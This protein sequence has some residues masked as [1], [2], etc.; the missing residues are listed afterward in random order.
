MSDTDDRTRALCTHWPASSPPVCVT[1][2]LEQ[3]S[4]DCFV[5]AHNVLSKI[6]EILFLLSYIIFQWQDPLNGG[7]TG[8]DKAQRDATYSFAIPAMIFGGGLFV[9]VLWS[10]RSKSQGVLWRKSFTTSVA[11]QSFV[12]FMLEKPDLIRSGRQEDRVAADMKVAITEK[13]WSDFDLWMHNNTTKW[14][15]DFVFLCLINT[16]RAT[17][18]IA[19]DPAN[20]FLVPSQLIVLVGVLTSLSS[21]LIGLQKSATSVR[22][23]RLVPSPRTRSPHTARTR[24]R[25]HVYYGSWS[26]CRCTRAGLRWWRW[27]DCSISTIVCTISSAVR[28]AVLRPTPRR[29]RSRRQ[30]ILPLLQEAHSLS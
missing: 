18:P 13:L 8:T 21:A 17:G 26:W 1:S 9:I 14:K 3:L 12:S 29:R 16:L 28:L 24:R 27:H 10:Y 11:V 7:R 2:P 30:R 20:G 15:L 6:W 4:S 5:G 19:A 22:V 23:L 25:G